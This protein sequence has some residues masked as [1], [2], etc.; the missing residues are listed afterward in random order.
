M[1]LP[2]HFLS[3]KLECVAIV[4]CYYLNTKLFQLQQNNVP[5]MYFSCSIECD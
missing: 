4:L 2:L 3:L 5:L 1:H